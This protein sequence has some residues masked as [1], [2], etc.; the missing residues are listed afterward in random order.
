MLLIRL[1][2]KLRGILAR[3]WGMPARPPTARSR[4]IG[5]NSE[6][7]LPDDDASSCKR[8]DDVTSAPADN[9]AQA[10]F[11]KLNTGFAF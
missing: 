6:A 9:G 7:P 11:R 4:A 8:N 3:F 10:D 2:L 5:T 1:L